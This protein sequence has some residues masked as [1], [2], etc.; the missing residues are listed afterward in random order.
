MRL[1][2]AIYALSFLGVTLADTDI[3]NPSS[4]H[5]VANFPPY[6]GVEGGTMVMANPNYRIL[7][8]LETCS[9]IFGDILIDPAFVYFI[10]NGPIE[11]TGTV[12]AH[13]SIIL[14]YVQLPNVTHLGGFSFASPQITGR[15]DLPV[16]KKIDKLEWRDITLIYD[17]DYLEWHAENLVAVSSLNVERTDLS[18]FFPDY[19]SYDGS[20]YYDGLQQLET[21]DHIRVVDNRRMDNVV[22]SGLKTVTGSLIVGNNVN[23][24]RSTDERDKDSRL[25]SFPALESA[26]S[27]V[28]YDD[29]PSSV[30]P[31]GKIDLP[32]LRHVSGD[33]N[34]TNTEGITDISVPCLTDIDGGLLI[35]GSKGLKNIDFPELRRIDHIVLDV[36]FNLYG[37]FQKVTFPVLEEVRSFH[38]SA[39]DF[40][41]SSLVHIFKIAREFSCYSLTAPF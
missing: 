41:C 4:F 18:G 23:S 27:V 31:E 5:S 26:G 35:R 33:F 29:A 17:D 38:V 24:H 16:V 39:Y 21:A 8:E 7:D 3:Y 37:G 36:G 25:I 11:I 19:E 28:I 15:I 10:L 30:P 22:F 32:V 9:T 2:T 12:I 40:N 13:D 6:C 14:K 20:F 1:A 34:V